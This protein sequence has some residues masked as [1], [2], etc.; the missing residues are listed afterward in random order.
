M[1]TPRGRLRA[2]QIEARETYFQ[3]KN[4]AS[5]TS[6]TITTM[7]IGT[8]ANDTPIEVAIPLPPLKPNKTVKLWPI[9]QQIPPTTPARVASA[10]VRAAHHTPNLAAGKPFHD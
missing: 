3:I 4:T 7:R 9:M 2:A 8:M 5:Q 1:R 6:S 10:P